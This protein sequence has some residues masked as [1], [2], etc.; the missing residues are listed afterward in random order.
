M[1]FQL[2]EVEQ[3]LQT[4]NCCVAVPLAESCVMLS[5]KEV[6]ENLDL[7]FKLPKD[8]RVHRFDRR[9]SESPSSETIDVKA[10]LHTTDG[11]IRGMKRRFND[12]KED[13]AR[14]N[15][16]GKVPSSDVVKEYKRTIKLT[17][18]DVQGLRNQLR[19]FDVED[20]PWVAK[21]IKNELDDCFAILESCLEGLE[22]EKFRMKELE[23]N[24]LILEVKTHRA[25]GDDEIG[26]KV[27]V[28]QKTPD[29]VARSVMIS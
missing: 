10:M 7:L 16:I 17:L 8:R 22:N 19:S 25:K 24:Y 15:Y 18:I 29:F 21:K 23:E 12:Y 20:R 1:S 11:R 3:L 5:L 2:V 6:K 9:R 4:S 27:V 26:R 14:R 28:G 13:A